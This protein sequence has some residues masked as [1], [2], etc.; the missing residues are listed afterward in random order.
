MLASTSGILYWLLIN[1][2]RV[3]SVCTCRSSL[4]GNTA[5]ISALS[6][7]LLFPLQNLLRVTFITMPCE[8]IGHHAHWLAVSQ[9]SLTLGESFLLFLLS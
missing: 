7:V 9:H 2:G 1:M 6:S 8:M 4:E 5:G 3:G